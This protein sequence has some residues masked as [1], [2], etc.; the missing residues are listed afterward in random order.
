MYC[1]GSHVVMQPAFALWVFYLLCSFACFLSL[2]LLVQLP[3]NRM[4]V[5]QL[6]TFSC[7]LY[8]LAVSYILRGLY[9]GPVHYFKEE[10]LSFAHIAW[11]GTLTFNGQDYS[12][13]AL[14]W[15][16]APEWIAITIPIL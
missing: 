8:R 16:Y 7:L 12:A 11:G 5:R 6:S 1:L 13:G 4:L 15:I 10:F 3:K 14:P 9:F 2:I